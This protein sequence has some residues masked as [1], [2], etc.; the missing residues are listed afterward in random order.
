MFLLFLPANTIFFL[1]LI[2]ALIEFVWYIAKPISLRVR[3][4]IYLMAGYNL[5]KVIV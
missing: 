5:L 1:A 4:F 3:L 2:L